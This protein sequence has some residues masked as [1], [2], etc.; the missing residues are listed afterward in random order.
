MP[1]PSGYTGAAGQQLFICCFTASLV[2]GDVPVAPAGFTTV[3]TPQTSTILLGSGV[4]IYI[5]WFRSTTNVS[6]ASSYTVTFSGNTIVSRLTCGVINNSTTRVNPT[7]S[8]TSGPTTL[9]LPALTTV[10]AN[11][12]VL[13]YGICDTGMTLTVPSG[14]SAATVE[15]TPLGFT[16]VWQRLQP[17]AGAIPTP[18]FTS[19]GGS[20]AV[21]GS[22]IAWAP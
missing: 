2:N 19:S 10:A 11:S 20:S 9:T 5:A 22:S 17:V 13:A 18:T 6:A 1:K 15:G 8:E 12:L 21:F 7:Y 16:D 3:G 14:Y 4:Y